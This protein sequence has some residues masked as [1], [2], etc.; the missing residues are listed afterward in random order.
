M[1]SIARG[2]GVGGAL[3]DAKADSGG[4]SRTTPLPLQAGSS[5]GSS[6]GCRRDE[7]AQPT[8]WSPGYP[9]HHRHHAILA[10]EQSTAAPVPSLEISNTF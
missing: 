8:R 2:R 10:G 6:S 4:S 3:E 5:S 9:G 7:L 1:R